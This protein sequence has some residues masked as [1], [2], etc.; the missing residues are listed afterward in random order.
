MVLAGVHICAYMTKCVYV[1]TWVYP[2]TWQ[3]V[4]VGS[5]SVVCAEGGAAVLKV[6]ALS[7]VLR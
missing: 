1:H 7:L 6:T 2:S 3:G 5:P 4:E